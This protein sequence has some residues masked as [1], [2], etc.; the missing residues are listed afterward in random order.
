M[1]EPNFDFAQAAQQRDAAVTAFEQAQARIADDR[2]L[3]P[4]GRQ[5]QAQR[6]EAN[7][8]ATVAGL[9]EA[10]QAEI[11]KARAAAEAGL[12]AQRT[13]LATEQYETLGGATVAQLIARDLATASP[14]EIVQAVKG[15]PG[16]KQTASLYTALAVAELTARV[17][18]G[19]R[20][21]EVELAEVQRLA[22]PADLQQ[23]RRRLLE[24]EATER[25]IEAWHPDRDSVLRARFNVR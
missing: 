3:S 16:H 17:R 23:V 15:A 22:E 24:L 2:E 5:A 18:A 21:A 9:I 1:N 13:R 11:A 6:V 20:A 19:D 14:A 10:G 8:R 25:E 4:E 7:Y 12:A